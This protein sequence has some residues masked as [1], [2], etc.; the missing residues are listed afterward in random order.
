MVDDRLLGAQRMPFLRNTSKSLFSLNTMIS[1]GG[2]FREHLEEDD[3][4]LQRFM[5]LLLPASSMV[6]RREAGTS[7]MSDRGWG[8]PPSTEK[9]EEKGHW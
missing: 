8:I 4:N 7:V 3:A 5:R 1:S 9:Q 2:A 6:A